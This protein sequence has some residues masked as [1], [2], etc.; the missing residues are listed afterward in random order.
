MGA[1]SNLLLIVPVLKKIGTGNSSYQDATLDISNTNQNGEELGRGVSNYSTSELE[2]RAK[3][4][5]EKYNLVPNQ[6][7][8]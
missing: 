7:A 1:I 8:D 5:R 6:L 3:S 2:A 4:A